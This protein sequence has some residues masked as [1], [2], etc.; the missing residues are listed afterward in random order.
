MKA[1][2]DTR[3]NKFALIGWAVTVIIIAV[4]YLIQVLKAERT[5]G[6]YLLLLLLAFAP[7]AAGIVFYRR[8]TETKALRGIIAI[9]YTILYGFVL[10]TGATILTFVYIFPIMSVLLVY[11]DGKLLRNF[12]IVNIIL[13]VI[14]VAIKAVVLHMTESAVIAEYEI[15][16]FDVLL[17]FVIAI[18]ACR[19][20]SNINE[21]KMQTIEAQA[22]QQESVLQSVQQATQVLN[23]RVSVIDRSAKD[24]EERSESAQASIEQIA[25]GTS[26]V[27]DNVQRQLEMSTGISGDLSSLTDIS[28]E[29]HERFQDTHRMSQEGVASINKLSQSAKLLEKTRD[30]VAV[31][32]DKLNR[33]VQEAKEILSL[34]RSVTDQ[35]NLLALNASIEAARAGEHGRG[36]AVVASEIQKL[37]GDSGDATDKITEIL[38]T[39]S[40][41]AGNVQEAV[42]SLGTVS[43]RQGELVEETDRQF[44]SIGENIEHMSE[45]IDRQN[46]YLTQINDNNTQIAGSISNTSA[47]TQQLTANSENTMNMTK[48]SL[49]GTREMTQSLNE[50]L[51]EVRKLQDIAGDC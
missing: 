48:E 3:K 6:Y 2:E 24:I 5:M 15:Q 20:Q 27:A 17:V 1:S 26:D 49:E 42:E 25:S 29:V 16:I 31:A 11:N 28:R 22:T 9:G 7:L 37:S 12:A 8:D 23:Q 39:L 51:G 18:F 45:E 40:K 50:I 21:E 19:I 10:W 47:Y 46:E 41:E 34:I 35:T 14:S 36:F 13:N 4:A 38:E 32:T 33:S 44:R 30:D 43:Q